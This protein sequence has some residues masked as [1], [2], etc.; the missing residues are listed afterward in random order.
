MEQC[1]NLF[2]NES[3]LLDCFKLFENSAILHNNGLDYLATQENHLSLDFKRAYEF[4]SYFTNKSFP[5]I[6]ITELLFE[7]Q[8]KKFY[9]KML[10]FEEKDNQSEFAIYLQ[11]NGLLTLKQTGYYISLINTVLKNQNEKP[12]VITSALIGLQN[13]LFMRT[14]IPKNELPIMYAMSTGAIASFSYWKNAMENSRH[15]WNP[16]TSQ[17]LRLPGWLRRGL[18]DLGG[19]VVGGLVGGLIAGPAGAVAG[20]TLVGTA[21]SAAN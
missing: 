11:T 21:C 9:D 15:P 7:D 10:E 20:G 18:R 5:T 14:D 1:E 3:Q 12:I 19:F 17:A 8:I 4:S 6:C 13:S 16:A 2:C